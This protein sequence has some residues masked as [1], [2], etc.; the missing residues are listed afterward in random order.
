MQKNLE[1]EILINKILL[2]HVETSDRI[3][4]LNNISKAQSAQDDFIDMK[5]EGAIVRRRARWSELGEK[6]RKYFLTLE[7]K[8]AGKKAINRLVGE[9]GVVLTDPEQILIKARDFYQALYGNSF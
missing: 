8:H 1:Q 3:N 5:T 6:N 4:I 2:K 7:S 9:E